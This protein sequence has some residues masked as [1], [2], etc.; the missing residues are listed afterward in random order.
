MPFTHK[1]KRNVLIWDGLDTGITDNSY[2]ASCPCCGNEENYYMKNIVSIDQLD[3]N[4]IRYLDENNIVSM[5]CYGWEAKKDIPAY[6]VFRSCHSCENDL[7][8]IVGMKEIQPQRYNIYYKS[9]V[10]VKK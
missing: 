9:T 2:S 5:G 7:W 8:F 6:S 3:G 1:G 10:Y 4:L